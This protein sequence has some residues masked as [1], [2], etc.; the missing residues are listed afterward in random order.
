MRK[1]LG[2]LLVSVSMGTLLLP[3]QVHAQTPAAPGAAG[4]DAVVQELRLLRRA[5]ERQSTTSARTQLLL[6]RLSLQDQRGAR[7]RQAVERLEVELLGAERERSQL[8]VGAREMTRALERATDPAERQSLEQ[9][10]RMMRSRLAATD[11]AVDGVQARL[12]QAK[13]VLE[14]DTARCDE[15]ENWLADV[16]RESQRDGS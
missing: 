8:Q 1:M 3:I 10:S 13:Q 7:S 4:L 15:L 6:A 5:V 9:E 12:A 2:W 16:E 14:A 11:S